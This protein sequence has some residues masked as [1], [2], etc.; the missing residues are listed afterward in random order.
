[1]QHRRTP[2]LRV[3]LCL[4][5]SK[6]PAQLQVPFTLTEASPCWSGDS[7]RAVRSRSY[8][9]SS[10]WSYPV[11]SMNS[12]NS[13]IS[14]RTAFC[15]YIRKRFFQDPANS[16]SSSSI[17]T[18]SLVICPEVLNDCCDDEDTF[19]SPKRIQILSNLDFFIRLWGELDVEA[20]QIIFFHIL[21]PGSGVKP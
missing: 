5:L 7:K 14:Q 20:V 1:M 6:N 9:S 8:S 18:I 3:R 21:S 15:I 12:D 2:T 10:S 16:S 17:S 4:L 11:N 13:F 19:P